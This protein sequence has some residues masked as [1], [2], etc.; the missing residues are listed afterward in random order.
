MAKSNKPDLRELLEDAQTLMVQTLLERLKA[1]T[2]SHQEMAIL[3]KELSRN[4][5]VLAGGDDEDEV[6]RARRKAAADL[7]DD[8]DEAE[9]E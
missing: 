8:L 3:Q 4:G 2:L 9:D 7:P 5:V 1:D 6:E